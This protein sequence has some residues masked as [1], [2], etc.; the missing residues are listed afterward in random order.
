[1]VIN[2]ITINYYKLKNKIFNKLGLNV[3]KKN[4]KIRKKDNFFILNYIKKS[5]KK[6]Y[7]QQSL[8]FL[9]KIKNYKNYRNI[10]G[11]PCLLYTS[12]AADE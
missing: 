3:K 4:L 8:L 10:M 9:N 7:E 2:K 6:T 5:K 1:M 11:Y 12:D